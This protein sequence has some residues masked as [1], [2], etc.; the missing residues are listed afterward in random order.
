M[1]KFV[2]IVMFCEQVGISR[3]TFYNNLPK[4]KPLIKSISKFSFSYI[5]WK[6]IKKAREYVRKN[7]KSYVSE[8]EFEKNKKYKISEA[9]KIIGMSST[10]FQRKLLEE[11]FLKLF[12]NS[13]KREKIK[14]I[15]ISSVEK[16]QNYFR[17]NSKMFS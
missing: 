11:D 15:E 6:D 13:E 8:V 16:V 5:H 3:E 9:L 4:I 7:S 12:V 2:N 14:G 10:S 1:E 17:E